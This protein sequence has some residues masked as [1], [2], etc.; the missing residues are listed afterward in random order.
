[1]TRET[2]GVLAVPIQ[3]GSP[4]GACPGGISS[5]PS[6]KKGRP[7]PPPLAKT[8]G[9]LGRFDEEAMASVLYV[10][11]KEIF[12]GIR[13]STTTVCLRCIGAIH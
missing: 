7:I 11:V 13:T 4:Q 6:A 1:M 10:S 5:H 3:N 8:G 9:L 12:Y 2:G